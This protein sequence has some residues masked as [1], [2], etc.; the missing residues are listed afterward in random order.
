MDGSIKLSAM[1]IVNQSD[2]PVLLCTVSFV[3]NV[4]VVIRS[5]TWACSQSD[6]DCDQ[7][8]CVS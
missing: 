1:S 6:V 5:K 8:T 4:L 3:Q 7:H 2:Q